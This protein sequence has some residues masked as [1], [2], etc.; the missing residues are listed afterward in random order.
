MAVPADDFVIRAITTEDAGALTELESR[1]VGSARWR[2]ASY[3]EIG[4]GG[5]VGWAA[6]REKALLGFILVRAAADEMEILN[7]AVDPEERR[8]GIAARLLAGAIEEVKRVGVKRV[9]LEVRELN[10]AAR[11]F[12]SSMGFLEQG[13]RKNY[14]SQPAEDALLLVLAL[15]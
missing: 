5:I 4:D 8:E 11:A 6:T 10:F 3:R 2:E 12:Y 7:L 13:R 14:Y 9:Y 1:C 15:C